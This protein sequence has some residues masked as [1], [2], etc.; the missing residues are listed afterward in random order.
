MEYQIT[1]RNHKVTPVTVEVSEPVAGRKLELQ[2]DDTRRQHDRIRSSCW[3]DGNATLDYG[4]QVK[5]SQQPAIGELLR[6]AS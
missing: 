6:P 2:V 1:P 3:A 4:V 5:W